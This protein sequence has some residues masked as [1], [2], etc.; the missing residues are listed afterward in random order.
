MSAPVTFITFTSFINLVNFIT[1]CTLVTTSRAVSTL[2]PCPR[3][4]GWFSCAGKVLVLLLH[5]I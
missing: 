5:A 3:R 1:F 4:P 2:D